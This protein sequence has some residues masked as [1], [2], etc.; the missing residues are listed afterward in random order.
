LQARTGLGT[1]TEMLL[2]GMAQ[3]G[4]QEPVAA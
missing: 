1:L 3:A 4:S 2:A